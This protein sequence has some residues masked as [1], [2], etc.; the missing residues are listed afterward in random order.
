MVVGS[1][2]LSRCRVSCRRREE[3]LKKEE[4]MHED[5]LR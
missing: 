5:E 3:E 2:T 4:E 1:R